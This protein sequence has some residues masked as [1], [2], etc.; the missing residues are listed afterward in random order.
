MELPNAVLNFLANAI[1]ILGGMILI[2]VS[3]PYVG[4][5]FHSNEIFGWYPADTVADS[6]CFPLT[7]GS[8]FSCDS[9]QY[10]LLPAGFMFDQQGS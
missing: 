2:I 4:F 1:L 6:F 7:D 9:Y 5:V 3:G 8:G 10:D